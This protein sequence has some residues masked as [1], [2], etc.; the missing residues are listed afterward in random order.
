MKKLIYLIAG[1]G[2]LGGFAACEDDND[3]PGDFSLQSALE[4][5][6]I[7]SAN[8]HVYPLTVE[9]TK[10]TTYEY[11][12]TVRDTLKDEN[13]EPILDAMG[14][15]QITA[16]EES[17]FSKKTAKLIKMQKVTL[18]GEA[19]TLTIPVVSNAKWSAPMPIFMRDG[20][21]M[22]PWFANYGST[23]A[24]GGNSYVKL[25]V[26]VG[27]SAR[28]FCGYQ[29]VLTSDSMIMY[30]IPFTQVGRGQTPPDY[31]MSLESTPAE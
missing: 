8:G 30:V 25:A 28:S 21:A 7:T 4:L 24:G 26:S 22:T 29:R 23:L 5:G 13:G 18:F 14:Q 20:N 27:R 12:Y 19:D 9:E 11:F 16:H 1:L 2:L 17:Y 15:L 31:D 10:D 3:N 6:T